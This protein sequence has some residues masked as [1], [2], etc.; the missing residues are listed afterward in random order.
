MAADKL[1]E[2]PDSISLKDLEK[3]IHNT[4]QLEFELIMLASSTDSEPP[5]NFSGYKSVDAIPAEIHL[6]DNAA[7]V[8][9]TARQDALK[10]S[11]KKRGA[12]VIASAVLRIGREPQFVVA[13]RGTLST[14][15]PGGPTVGSTALDKLFS[16]CVI[17]EE[18]LKEVDKIV[19]RIES[20]RADY[21]RVA[22][23]TGSPG[24]PWYVIAFIHSLESDLDF[25]THLHNG[26][27][28]KGRT[29]HEPRNMPVNPPADGVRY[30]WHE[31]AFDALK[32]D[33]ALRNRDWTVG[34]ILDF[35]ERFNGLGYR[36]RGIP[37]PYL[38]SFSNHYEKGK[39]I[40]DGVFSPTKVSKQCGAA[41]LL[42]RLM[43]QNKISLADKPGA[44]LPDDESPPPRPPTL[45]FRP[46]RNA[47]VAKVQTLLRL[48]GF[49]KDI[50]DGDFGPLTEAAVRRFQK[51]VGLDSTG[52][53]NDETL[54]ALKKGVTPD[55]EIIPM[56]CGGTLAEQI[57]SLAEQEA[58]RNLSWDGP[59]SEAERLYLAP[60]RP[61]MRRLE[62]VGDAT[63]F[64]NWCSCWVTYVLRSVGVSVPDQPEGFFATVAL[65]DAME[66]WAK[67]TGTYFAK[68]EKQPQRGDV[69]FFQFDSDVAEDHIGIVR[70]VRGTTLLTAEGNKGNRAGNFERSM[71]FASGFMRPLSSSHPQALLSAEARGDLTSR[72]FPRSTRKKR[73]QTR[74]PRRRRSSK[75]SS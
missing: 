45:L 37:S 28:L 16:T 30:T 25:H 36:K 15:S 19:G 3:A 13:Y 11:L 32:H 60:L 40:D 26:D 70:E 53:V 2:H 52:I 23:Q 29:V 63:T 22:G 73:L 71:S 24:V 57:A 46:M 1:S 17:R 67:E 47:A 6:I 75:S 39:F 35:L 27:P 48:G 74:K 64:F 66:F 61:A 56:P 9:D 31:S 72:E 20:H 51:T 59:S 4:E 5:L 34:G 7:S 55:F 18:R 8:D 58:A 42:K 12:R 62:H 38:W 69:V 44:S 41:V 33:G 50:V 68:G 65:V 21:D 43:D 10:T 54:Q 49:L 14:E